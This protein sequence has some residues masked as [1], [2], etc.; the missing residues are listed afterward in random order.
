MARHFQ[1][2]RVNKTILYLNV[3]KHSN[4]VK[5]DNSESGPTIAIPYH[6]TEDSSQDRLVPEAR[7]LENNRFETKMTR[8]KI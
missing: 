8:N 7:S 2:H 5:K 4:L 1:K 3:T 6:Q